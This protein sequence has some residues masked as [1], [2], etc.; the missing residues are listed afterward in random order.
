MS[1]NYEDAS[2]KGAEKVSQLSFFCA[3]HAH[4]V[5][6]IVGD[7][8]FNNDGSNSGALSTIEM[9]PSSHCS[10]CLLNERPSRTIGQCRAFLVIKSGEISCL[11]FAIGG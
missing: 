4:R 8:N 2:L 6:H 1:W 3:I 7:D 9:G 10:S 5:Y 11:R